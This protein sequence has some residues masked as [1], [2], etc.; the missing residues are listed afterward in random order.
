MSTQ[1]GALVVSGGVGIGGNLRV[2]GTTYLAGDLFVDG[3]QFVVD[4]NSIR[5]G[6][7]TLVLSSATT[8]SSM[9]AGSGIVVGPVSGFVS[10]LF[11]GLNSWVSK[12]NMLPGGPYALGSSSTAWTSIYGTEVYD[13]GSR[14][15]TSLTV[16]AGRGLTGGGTAT[17]YSNS[18]TLNA[19]I[20]QA[21]TDTAIATSTDYLTVFSTS[22]LDTVARRGSTATAAITL[23]NTSTNALS[24]AGGINTRAL[25]FPNQVL[26]G[27]TGILVQGQ[28]NTVTDLASKVDAV[29][30]DAWYTPAPV[31]ADGNPVGKRTLY[32]YDGATW[33]LSTDIITNYQSLTAM[34][35][36]SSR[37]YTNLDVIYGPIGIESFQ[38]GDYYFDDGLSNPDSVDQRP[39]LYIYVDNGTG[40]YSLIDVLP[41]P[42]V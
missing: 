36:R 35:A 6:D 27:S 5:T 34:Y 3:T 39:H 13:G 8:T 20:I 31:D 21:G 1:T 22:T 24:V 28:I 19:P 12:A 2:S 11:D 26:A 9:A 4:S 37:T 38:P 14:V 17:A 15:L 23:S 7:K 29:P 10:L 18:V 41:L 25:N 33:K 42:P 32:I 30:N 40:G 16:N